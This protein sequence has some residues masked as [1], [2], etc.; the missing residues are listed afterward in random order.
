MI[1]FDHERTLTLRQAAALLPGNPNRSTIHRWTHHGVRGV[2]LATILV[3]GRRFTTRDAIEEFISTLSS[4]N[5]AG[6]AA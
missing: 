3:G 2:R 4:Q 5:G 1:T 6:D